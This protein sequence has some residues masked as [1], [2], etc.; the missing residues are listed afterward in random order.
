ML[1]QRLG[2]MSIGLAVVCTL[3]GFCLFNVAFSAGD[4]ARGVEL[5]LSVVAVRKMTARPD[6]EHHC[7]AMTT[8]LN[9]VRASL[10][11]SQAL[12]ACRSVA[13]DQLWCGE[14]CGVCSI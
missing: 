7:L 9:A 14:Y 2:L 8:L 10:F 13:Y 11:H 5:W 12:A 3:R 1:S 6:L 4:P